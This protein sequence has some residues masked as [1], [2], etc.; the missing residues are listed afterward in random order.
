MGT[1]AVQ[2]RLVDAFPHDRRWRPRLDVL[3]VV[4]LA[5]MNAIWV[6]VR[7]PIARR[8]FRGGEMDVGRK[9]CARVG[10]EE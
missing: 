5:D 8:H 7:I 6:A 3:T 4:F 1:H 10:G 9:L 2:F